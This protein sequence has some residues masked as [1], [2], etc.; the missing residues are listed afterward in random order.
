MTMREK[1]CVCISCG[2]FFWQASAVGTGSRASAVTAR[3]TRACASTAVACA[4]ATTGAKTRLFAAPF[5]IIFKNDLFAKTGSGQTYR[6]STHNKRSMHF[7]TAPASA[8]MA[9]RT[10]AALS[11]AAVRVAD[12]IISRLCINHMIFQSINPSIN[13]LKFIRMTSSSPFLYIHYCNTLLFADSSSLVS[14]TAFCVQTY[15]SFRSRAR[16]LH[17]RLRRRWCLPHD[18]RRTRATDV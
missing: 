8:A 3:R 4:A 15:V 7:L 17:R 13:S 2:L 11:M 12:I 9:F 14:L 18:R 10:P 5:V 6:E 16:M 1:C